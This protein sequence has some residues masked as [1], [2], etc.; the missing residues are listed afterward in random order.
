MLSVTDLRQ[1]KLFF[2]G[3]DEINHIICSK[4]AKAFIQ[5]MPEDVLEDY[6]EYGDY[7]GDANERDEEPLFPISSDAV[8]NYIS[9]VRA[10]LENLNAK[11]KTVV[12][13]CLM[14]SL[15][16]AKTP[17]KDETDVRTKV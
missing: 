4:P 10:Q 1:I 15:I 14:D 8:L 13:D 2:K 9:P 5:S 11:L 6:D 16:E 17:K 3:F 7:C 12:M